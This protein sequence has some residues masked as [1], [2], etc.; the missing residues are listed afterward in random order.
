MYDP[1]DPIELS[2]MF[3]VWSA[4][5]SFLP[6]FNA[7]GQPAISL[8][9]HMSEGGLPIGMQLVGG[10]GQESLLL[11]LAGQLEEAVPWDGRTPPI[12]VSMST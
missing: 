9:L 2:R 10:F 7:T 12:H 1:A 4:W 5:E 6:A 11:R 3:E 8:P